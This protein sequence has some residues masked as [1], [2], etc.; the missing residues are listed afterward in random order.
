MI[1]E[2]RFDNMDSIYLAQAMYQWRAFLKT[3]MKLRIQ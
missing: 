1:I 2:L 3:E